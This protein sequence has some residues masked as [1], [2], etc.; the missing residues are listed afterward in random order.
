MN[1]TKLNYT[2]IEE[3][4]RKLPWASCPFPL[5]HFVLFTRVFAVL[6]NIKHQWQCQFHVEDQVYT[7]D[8]NM[9]PGP[10]LNPRRDDFLNK[11]PYY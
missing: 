6:N 9:Y 3:A 10:G 7:R 2:L 1:R 8:C 5:E 11:F 4:E